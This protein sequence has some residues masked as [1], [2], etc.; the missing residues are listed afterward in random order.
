MNTQE[1]IS[2]REE[3]VARIQL[4]NTQENTALATS[5]GF[6]A[7]NFAFYAV[8]MTA[9]PADVKH[10]CHKSIPVNPAIYTNITYDSNCL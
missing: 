5:M 9:K 3:L 8:V 1:Y 6:W 7:A 10:R 2:L 4:V